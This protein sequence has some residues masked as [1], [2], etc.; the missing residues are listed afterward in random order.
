MFFGIIGLTVTDTN[1]SAFITPTF[2]WIIVYVIK[3]KNN[4]TG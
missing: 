3:T 1:R 4:D 2:L